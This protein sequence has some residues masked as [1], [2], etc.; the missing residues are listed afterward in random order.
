MIKYDCEYYYNLLKI[1]SNTAQKIADVRWK[2]IKDNLEHGDQ[3]V[4]ALDYGCGVGFIKAFAPDWIS[5]VD[6]F[7]IMPIPQTGMRSNNY[8]IVMMYD[9]LEH[10]PDFT[11]MLPTLNMTRYVAVTV[12]MKPAKLRGININ[13]SS[14]ENIFTISP[15]IFSRISSR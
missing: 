10:I 14:L 15:M 7:D 13:T 6:T 1:H 9:V 11:E 2:F 5:E 3:L 4:N 8:S 12:P